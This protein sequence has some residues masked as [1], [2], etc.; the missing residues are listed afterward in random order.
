MS[1]PTAR[2]QSNKRIKVVSTGLALLIA[3]FGLNYLLQRHNIF[4]LWE[5]SDYPISW[6]DF[7]YPP[8]C[9]LLCLTGI[10]LSFVGLFLRNA[11]W[12][13]VV[14]SAAIA[15]PLTVVYTMFAF[16][17]QFVATGADRLGECPSLDQAAT[18][19]GV[20][21]ESQW[22]KGH[23]AV[24]CGVQ[25]RGMFLSYYNDMAVFGVTDIQAQQSVLDEITKRYRQAHTHPV[26]VRFL[27]RAYFS[28]REGT[29][30]ATIGTKTGP[31]KLIRVVNIG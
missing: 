24:G 11:I 1:E 28:I 13:S 6:A 31:S 25:R 12:R 14:Y 26:Q 3:G 30:G 17:M 27:D 18:S 19:T 20:I 5:N 2:G 29:G 23:A 7:A 10:A 22:R 16:G 21:P 15:V 4:K 8:V 9:V